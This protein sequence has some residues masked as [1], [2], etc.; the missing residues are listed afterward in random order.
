[1]ECQQIAIAITPDNG[2]T[3]HASNGVREQREGN[4]IQAV[5]Q[6]W[7][8]QVTPLPGAAGVTGWDEAVVTWGDRGRRRN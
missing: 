8:V 6:G 4:S 3:F 5:C 7:M 2:V 1:M